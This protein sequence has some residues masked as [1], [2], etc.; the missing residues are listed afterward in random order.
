M[1]FFQSLMQGRRS[2]REI[3]SYGT[4]RV[5]GK[6]NQEHLVLSTFMLSR[7]D[8]ELVPKTKIHFP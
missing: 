1:V 4:S 2:S 6:K 5:T 8:G 7:K 3:T